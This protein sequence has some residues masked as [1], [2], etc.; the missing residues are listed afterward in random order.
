M[1]GSEPVVSDARS[2]RVGE[3]AVRRALPARGRRTVG[4]WCFLDHMG[5]ATYSVDARY[6]VAPHPH[7]GLQT[8]TWLF[9]GAMLHRDSL[10]SEQM[11]RPGQLNLMTSGDGVAHSEEN[12]GLASGELHGVQMWV[13]LPTPA[14]GGAAAFEHHDDLPV[15]A[16]DGGELTV[17]M[18]EVA[19]VASPAK[20]FSELV[21]AQWRVGAGESVLPLAPTFEHAVVVTSGAVEIAGAPL[22]P[23]R[24][25]YL[26]PGRDEVALRARGSATGVL[27]GG[28]PFDETVVMWWNFVARSRDEISAAYEAWL[29]RDGRFGDVAS[30]LARVEV[31]APPWYERER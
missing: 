29:K 11:I 20:R 24:L 5:P 14:R 8:V 30:D 4:A 26:A 28:V 31:V 16:V 2:S 17:L 25:A 27:I 18:G 6:D 1:V 12:P 13:A 19:G 9:E 15:V 21:G 10:G 7:I 23:G 3:L 22:A